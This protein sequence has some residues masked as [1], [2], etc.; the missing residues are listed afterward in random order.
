M[1]GRSLIWCLLIVPTGLIAQTNV[2]GQAPVTLEARADCGAPART[3][4]VFVDVSGLMGSGGDAGINAFVLAFVLDHGETFQAAV[5]GDDPLLDWTFAATEVAVVTATGSL[6]LV[7]AVADT[8][9]PNQKYHLATLV[10]GG[11]TSTVTLTFN[12]AAS[13]LSSRVIDGDGPGPILLAA[14]DPLTLNLVALSF[15]EGVASWR[16]FAPDYDLVPPSGAIDIVDLVA[17]AACTTA[18]R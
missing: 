1:L 17:L 4:D 12:E 3:V 11:P 16:Q 13:S 14:P 9:A 5:A 18:A 2:A 8:A 15:A 10:F 6:R 7:G